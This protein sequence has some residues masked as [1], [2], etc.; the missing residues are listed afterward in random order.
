MRKNKI[1][2]SVYSKPADSHLYLYA[3]FCHKKSTIK[4]VQKYV[5][6][7]LRRICSTSNEYEMKSKEYISH[8]T[9]RGHDPSEVKKLFA[10][11]YSL[12][13]TDA[14]KKVKKISK[15]IISY[16]APTI[17]HHLLCY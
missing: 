13:R 14:R 2:T 1:N 11:V 9:N 17:I 7:R 10:A 5:A 4:G 12:T 6:L 3:I 15:M 16:S 8:L